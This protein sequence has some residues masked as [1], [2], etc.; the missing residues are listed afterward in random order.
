MDNDELNPVA[1]ADVVEES[2]EFARRDSST[3]LYNARAV[4]VPPP[5]IQSARWRQ[6]VKLDNFRF[7]ENN[8]PTQKNGTS[9]LTLL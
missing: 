4:D 8:R 3:R 7:A 5:T 9:V 1:Q 2:F 6:T